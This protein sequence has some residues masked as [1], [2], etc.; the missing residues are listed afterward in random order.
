MQSATINN[1]TTS[2]YPCRIC[3]KPTKQF[4]FTYGACDACAKRAIEELE[5]RER[6]RRIVDSRR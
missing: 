2:N 5:T 6:N 4:G 3:G 1:A